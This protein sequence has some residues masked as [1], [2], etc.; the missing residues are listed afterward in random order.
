MEHG[1]PILRRAALLPT[2]SESEEI[3]AAS[4]R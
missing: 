2:K 1:T 4:G 3:Q